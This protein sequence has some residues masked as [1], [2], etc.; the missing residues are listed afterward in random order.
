[1]LV[2]SRKNGECFQIGESILVKVTA[3]R[4]GRV[5]IAIDAPCELPIRRVEIA[6]RDDVASRSDLPSN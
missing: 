4:G 3:I 1:M 2:L 6:Q 5:K